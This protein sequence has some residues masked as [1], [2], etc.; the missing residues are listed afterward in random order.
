M[1][2][3][4]SVLIFFL[5][6]TALQAQVADSASQKNKK[7]NMAQGSTRYIFFPEENIYLNE[8]NGQYAY[9]DPATSM[10]TT[11]SKLPS[12]YFINNK[13]P[14]SIVY[15]SGTDVWKDN[16]THQK[17]YAAGNNKSPKP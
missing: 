7:N 11:N 9:Y 13:T 12:T 10:W 17:N 8:A 2:K 1:K 14:K 3:S 15:Y 6:T 16:A 4:M 5:F